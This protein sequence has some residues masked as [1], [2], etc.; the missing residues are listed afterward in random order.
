MRT[1]FNSFS[2]RITGCEKIAAG[3]LLA[4]ALTGLADAQSTQQPLSDFNNA[5]G[6]TTCFTPPAPAQLGWGTGVDADG[7]I[8]TNGNA[9]NLTPP[10]FALVDYTGLEGRFLLDHYGINLG[11]TVSGTVKERSL[12]DGHALVTVDVHTNPC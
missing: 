3:L 7:N 11:T 2:N 1:H 6:T 4:A 12:A 8:K 9:D 5:Q 10:R